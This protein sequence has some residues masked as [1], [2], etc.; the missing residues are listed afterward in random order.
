MS[1]P[2]QILSPVR[3]KLWLRLTDEADDEYKQKMH[4]RLSSLTVMCW[5]SRQTAGGDVSLLKFPFPPQGSHLRSVWRNNW[6]DRGAPETGTERSSWVAATS[7]SPGWKGCGP[8]WRGWSCPCTAAGAGWS[9]PAPSEPPSAE[10][11]A[12]CHTSRNPLDTQQNSRVC[13]MEPSRAEF[14]YNFTN[15]V[16]FYI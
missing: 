15:L 8:G 10:D 14:K 13:P 16:F 5:S 7:W 6:N 3:W 4:R 1:H 2:F 12:E 9:P 11:R